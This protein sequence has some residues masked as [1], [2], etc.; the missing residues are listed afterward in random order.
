LVAVEAGH[1]AGA[2][3]AK[4]CKGGDIDPHLFKR[5]THAD[6]NLRV[7]ALTVFLQVLQ[8]IL[9]DVT[10]VKVEPELLPMALIGSGA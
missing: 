3:F 5:D 6:S 10:P 1:F 4:G 8:D 7:K 9:H 2:Y